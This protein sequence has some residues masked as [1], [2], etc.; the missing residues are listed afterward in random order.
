MTMEQ[1]FGLA[2]V[3]G[4]AAFVAFAFRQGM[5]VKPDDR[6]DQSSIQPRDLDRLR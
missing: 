5:K 4:L 3:L 1:L 6:P 2:A